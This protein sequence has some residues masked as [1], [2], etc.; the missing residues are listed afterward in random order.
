MTLKQAEAYS[1]LPARTLKAWMRS[2]RLQA[3]RIGKSLR[4]FRQD[5]DD[6]VRANPAYDKSGRAVDSTKRVMSQPRNAPKFTPK[7]QQAEQ[8]SGAAQ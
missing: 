3:F 5:L 4:V 1:G 6:A 8:S 7:P 2:G